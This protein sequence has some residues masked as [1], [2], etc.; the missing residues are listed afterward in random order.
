MIRFRHNLLY[1]LP[2]FVFFSTFFNL[3]LPDSGKAEIQRRLFRYVKEE[4]SA[5]PVIAVSGV[6]S[7]RLNKARF[8]IDLPGNEPLITEAGEDGLVGEAESRDEATALGVFRSLKGKRS[9]G[10]YFLSRSGDVLHGIFRRNENTYVLRHVSGAGSRARYRIEKADPLN[11][12]GCGAVRQEGQTARAYAADT[13]VTVAAA[14]AEDPESIVTLMVVYPPRAREAAGGQKAIRAEINTAVARMNQ[15]F[16]NSGVRFRVNLVHTMELS[17]NET[18]NMSADLWGLVDD[19]GS[20]TGKKGRWPEVYKAR[21]RYHADLVALI[22]EKRE[23]NICGLARIAL[24]NYTADQYAFSATGRDCLAYNTLAHEIGHNLGAD[25][26]P[27]NSNNKYNPLVAPYARGHIFTFDKGRS[28]YGTVMSY[29]PYKI[30]HFSNPRVKFRGAPTGTSERDNA[31]RLNEM[32]RYVSA[33]RGAPRILKQPGNS[34]VREGAQVKLSVEAVGTRP[35]TF[36]W[37]KNGKVIKG[38][39]SY[40]SSGDDFSHLSVYN[41]T[42]DWAGNYSVTVKNAAGSIESK[43]VTVTVKAKTATPTPSP[44]RTATKTP[45][46]KATKQPTVT[47]SPSATA[48]PKIT[49]TETPAPVHTGEPTNKPSPVPT[50]TPAKTPTP[51]PTRTSTPVPTKIPTKI[52]TKAPTAVP[53]VTPTKVPTKAPTSTPTPSPTKTPAKTSTPTPAPAASYEVS[54][55][56]ILK[57]PNIDG[58][59]FVVT[60]AQIGFKKEVEN[61]NYVRT[62]PESG[63]YS[64]TLNEGSYSVWY[65]GYNEKGKSSLVTLGSLKHNKKVSNLNFE[66]TQELYIQWLMGF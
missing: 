3:F 45:S 10:D 51:A 66:F 22:V 32:F 59:Y 29:H 2:L 49:A 19:D 5:A 14:A 31:R 48:T 55:R 47:A 15:T 1:F 64:L 38:L 37:K 33:F 54:G 25:H 61:V 8:R 40:I 26:D 63:E 35:F 34:S 65:R 24:Q 62:L 6:H 57:V 18:G 11:A 30:D 50:M 27:D 4:G 56:V 46:P 9:G 42:P 36:Q 39:D 17:R 16:A 41:I 20:I 21:D 53:T 28:Y 44:T 23:P 52:P 60:K 7:K 12:G 43:T 13:A 58:R